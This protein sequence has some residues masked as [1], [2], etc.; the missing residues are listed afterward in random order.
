M[1][2]RKEER[3]SVAGRAFQVKNER[4]T[5]DWRDETEDEEEEEDRREEGYSCK[6]RKKGSSSTPQYR[7]HKVWGLF[8][9]LV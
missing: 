5:Q 3:R 8:S 1:C 6:W 7:Y 4:R 2:C 9:I